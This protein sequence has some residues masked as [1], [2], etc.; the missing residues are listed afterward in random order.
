MIRVNNRNRNNNR[1]TKLTNKER[2]K[3]RNGNIKLKD[4]ID[5]IKHRKEQL[6]KNESVF[7]ET[8]NENDE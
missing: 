7:I 8:E 5:T 3:N 6:I 1:Q 4:Y 2:L